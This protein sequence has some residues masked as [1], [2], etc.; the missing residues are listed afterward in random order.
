M[1]LKTSIFLVH[2][3]GNRHREN[4]SLRRNLHLWKKMKNYLRNG[5]K[6]GQR[7]GL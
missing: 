6:S 3:H 5:W 7:Y 1:K 2:R 4:Q